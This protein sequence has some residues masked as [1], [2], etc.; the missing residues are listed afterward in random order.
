MALLITIDD[1]VDYKSLNLNQD[2]T[3]SLDPFIQESQDFDLKN[4]MG[5]AFYYDF[6][7][8]VA[9]SKYQ[10]L[11]NGKVYVN[12]GSD[13]VQFKGVA[14]VLV[15][16]TY[17]RYVGKKNYTDTPFGLVTKKG[18]SSEPIDNKAMSELALQ[19]RSGAMAFWNDVRAFLNITAN[20]SV[21]PLWEGIKKVQTV[22]SPRI[23][24]VGFNR[25]G[26]THKHDECC[27]RYIT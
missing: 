10:D 1:F 18:E 4:L 15:Y 22:T 9:D 26:K 23:H 27:K 17:A 6:V 12:D 5:D 13:N 25:A 3:R 24:R 11:L 14:A 7:T 19:A 16:F 2:Q 8:N 20:S 21:Y